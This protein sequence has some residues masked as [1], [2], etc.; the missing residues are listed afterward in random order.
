MAAMARQ[1]GVLSFSA[2]SCW[3]HSRALPHQHLWLDCRAQYGGLLGQALFVPIPQF[4]AER[5]PAQRLDSSDFSVIFRTC[6]QCTACTGMRHCSTSSSTVN[7]LV[8]GSQMHSSLN[9]VGCQWR[10]SENHQHRYTSND[11]WSRTML[12][13]QSI[14]CTCTAVHLP[15]L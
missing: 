1:M 9:D 4:V 13:Q 10:C 2:C 12:R 8:G 6:C 14:A 11:N 7:C 5:L 15:C 3:I